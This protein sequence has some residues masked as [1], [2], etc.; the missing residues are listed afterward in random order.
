MDFI[1]EA[2]LLVVLLVFVVAAASLTTGPF[3]GVTGETWGL[4]ILLALGLA[5]EKL[6]TIHHCRRF[7][8]E[9]IPKE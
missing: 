4:A 1:V 5:V 6:L 3:A 7:I 9:F 2:Y 8:R